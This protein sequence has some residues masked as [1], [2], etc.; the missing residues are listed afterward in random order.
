MP[1]KSVE[2]KWLWLVGVVALLALATTLT[3]LAGGTKSPL[4]HAFYIP[5]VTA[6]VVLGVRAGMTTALIAGV[7]CG[8]LMPLDVVTGQTQPT[9]G[10]LIRLAFF[11]AIAA[12]VGVGR[13]RLLELSTA[14][15]RFLS[16]VSHELRTPLSSV[17]GFAAVLA[18]R[19]DTLTDA[20]RQAFAQLILSESRELSNVVDHYVLAG[21]LDDSALVIDSSPTDL[22][23]LVDIVLEGLPGQIRNARVDV[24]GREAVC[25]ADPVRLRQM[26]RAIINNA[27]AYTTGPISVVVTTENR[28]AK[29]KVTDER[30]QAKIG[31]QVLRPANQPAPASPP[32]LGIGLAVSRELARLMGGD[33]HY[34]VNG[35]TVFELALPLHPTPRRHWF[36]NLR[37]GPNLRIHIGR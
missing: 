11:L 37:P 33:L 24:T 6:A 23:R 28:Y 4:P 20:E 35:S 25:L 1:R 18:E 3:Y 5:V 27:L 21:R 8:P 30:G 29:L 31:L 16:G 17:L 36:G 19:S 26:L 9:S 7:L 2:R 32:P 10:W 34:Q 22:R 14:R 15:Q 13:N 12:V